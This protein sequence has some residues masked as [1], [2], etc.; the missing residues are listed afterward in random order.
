MSRLTLGLVAFALTI[1]IR[2][3]TPPTATPTPVPHVSF[4]G[5]ALTFDFPGVEIGAS[6]F[7]RTS[8]TAWSDAMCSPRTR[9]LNCAAAQTHS[10]LSS[11]DKHP[12]ISFLD[13]RSCLQRSQQTNLKSPALGATAFTLTGIQMERSSVSRSIRVCGPCMRDD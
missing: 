10:K 1:P 7:R 6:R 12:T 11:A 9:S 2:A 8:S 13:T 5:P 4:D 3:A